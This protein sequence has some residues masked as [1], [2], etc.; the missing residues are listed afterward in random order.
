MVVTISRDELASAVRLH[1]AGDLVAA[2]RLYESILHRD[3][4]H[5][6][7]LH[8]LG[9]ARHQQ[10]QSWLAVDLIGRAV[11]LH[12]AVAIFHATLGE[13]YRA[14]GQF[15]R[16]ASSCR[17][18]LELGLKDPAVQNNLGLALHALGRPAEAAVAFR[19]VLEQW[20]TDAPAHTNLGAALR[21]LD[22][23]DEA[24][25]H[26]RRAVAI[27]PKLAAAQ[28][29][30]GQLLLDLGRPS[31]ALPHCRE[32]VI[33]QPNLPEAHNNLGNV[34]RALG[35]LPEA[36]QC[37]GEAL[38][39]NP[40]LAQAHVSLGLTLQQAERWDEAL[41][42]LR[43]A[44]ELEP[45]SLEFLALLAEAAVEREIFDEA[46]TCYQK[47]LE[48]D[49]GLAASHNALGW[50]LQEEGRLE[51]AAEH[52][53]R[54]LELRPEHTIA[55]VNL[56]GV[57]EKLGDF[58]AA[59]T[60]FRAAL[61]ADESAGLALARL[62]MLLGGKLPDAERERIEERLARSDASDPTRL[63]LLFGLAGVCDARKCYA[64]AA[65]CAREANS[66]AKAELGRRKLGY[67]PA[68]HDRL[69]S[70]LIEAVDP[71]YFS[72]LA[73]AGLDTR[74]PIFVVGL[75]R[76]GTSLIEQIL[77]SH[78]QCHGAGEL[79]LARQGFGA[80]PDLLNRAQPSLACIPLLDREAVR[81]LAS[82]HEHRL[83]EIDGGRAARIADKMPDN[84]LHLGL[85]ATLFP[86]AVL[87]HCRRD[88]RDVA[89]SCWITGFR[90]MRW[91][92]EVHHIASRFE[93]HR[94]LMNHWRA[95]LPVPIHE[96]DYE[97]T[98]ADLESSARKLL[99][100]CSLDWEPACL[101]FH[102]T[103]RTVRTASFTQVRQPVYQSSAGRWRNY[104]TELADLFAA[105]PGDPDASHAEYLRLG[106]RF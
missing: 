77:A 73:G 34:Q 97:E 26:L 95:V 36:L 21:A 47:M 83:C 88:L 20:P 80:L 1:Q 45:N 23:T 33:L 2:T 105:L 55:H 92:N 31:E 11:A 50:L 82:W 3:T 32:A 76:S 102:R 16:A 58:A 46:T 61:E 13:A 68:D 38:R 99:A 70:G 71:A 75:P 72:R 59:E 66:L 22:S 87:I 85:L 53:R 44:C 9:L 106:I 63:N 5:A 42:W 100:A 64:R 104:Q 81:H 62:A 94:R 86:R 91:T 51:E 96:V 39:L 4:S 84:Y 24:L 48:L 15:D 6:D 49:P 8:L 65:D 10:G 30:L 54:S 52:L 98:V 14:L 37:Y 89:V 78:S 40:A 90:S 101:D 74:R 57:H 17:S 56:G 35:R 103:R 18:A 19:A 7:A 67:D 41:P 69:V 12:P 29:N 93:Q 28:S 25:A 27:D 79:P 43:R 60:C